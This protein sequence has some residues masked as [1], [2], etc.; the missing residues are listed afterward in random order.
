MAENV[1]K[2][3]DD[4]HRFVLVSNIP[5]SLHTSD[6]RKF[7]SDFVE[8]EKFK[9]FHF[10]HRPEKGRI[11]ENTQDQIQ[12]CSTSFSKQ[13]CG[14]V[15]GVSDVK[16]DKKLTT[17][18]IVQIKT[19][20]VQ[21]LIQKYHRKHWLDSMGE[22]MSSVCLVFKV[23]I[24][25]KTT[26][27]DKEKEGVSYL[28]SELMSLLELKPPNM[29]PHGNVGTS[30]KFFLKAINECRLPAK[31]VGKLKLEFPQ[32]RNRKF[33]NVPFDYGDTENKKSSSR[34]VYIDRRILETKNKQGP[35]VSEVGDDD[36]D[37]DTCEEWERHEALHNDVQPNRAHGFQVES[38]SYYA[39]DA[40]LEQQEGCK[41]KTFE[42]EIELVWEKGGSGLNFYTDAQFWKEREGDFDE[43]TSDDWDVDMN[44]YYEKN[45]THDR[46]AVD[47]VE[48]RKSDF[49]REGKHSESLFRKKNKNNSNFINGRRKRKLSGSGEE[50]IGNFETTSRGVGGKIMTTAGWKP[51]DG[52]GKNNQGIST[53]ILGEEEGQGPK[54]KSGIGYYGEKVAV[55]KR[56]EN[57]ANNGYFNTNTRITTAFSTEE[58]KKNNERYDRSSHTM[59]LKFR[60]S[61]VKFHKGGVEG[62]SKKS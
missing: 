62:G 18:C 52:L 20:Q 22:E 47:S 21:N 28:K 7:F 3:D 49:L 11:S 61:V 9:C 38:T 31:L 2:L 5:A 35:S 10:R 43:K 15:H 60:D 40:D 4:D 8:T 41:E 32:A 24:N 42:D 36:Q 23:K 50:K 45:T 6:L 14:R 13:V 29:M 17:C 56:P 44:V 30:T 59:Y 25:T 48:M 37:N 39:A 33:G 12:K 55:F 16:I 26:L 53:P 19:D 57:V 51:G 34:N 54:D 58:E 46:D 27:V 1:E